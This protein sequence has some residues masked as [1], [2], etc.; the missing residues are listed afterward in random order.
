MFK[1]FKRILAALFNK[2]YQSDLDSLRASYCDDIDRVYRVLFNLRDQIH[3][4]PV[5][6]NL[7]GSEEKF[8]VEVYTHLPD[9]IL[10]NKLPH[11]ISEK[12][13]EDLRSKYEGFYGGHL[14]IDKLTADDFERAKTGDALSILNISKTILFCNF[15]KYQRKD[16]WY[17]KMKEEN[18]CGNSAN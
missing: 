11:F 18:N 8:L 13:F 14:E 10:Y 12:D 2:P 16:V 15:E 5:H 9:M 17:K 1:Y 7:D 3:N 6:L 4:L